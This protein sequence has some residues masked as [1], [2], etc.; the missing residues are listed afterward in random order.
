MPPPI[1]ATDKHCPYRSQS[2]EC[3]VYSR[4]IGKNSIYTIQIIRQD[5]VS[6]KMPDTWALNIF[7]CVLHITDSL[8]D[9]HHNYGIDLR[10]S[11]DFEINATFE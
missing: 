7:L 9:L 11:C 1:N 5:F 6:E 3:G 4:I 8:N 10:I 2:E